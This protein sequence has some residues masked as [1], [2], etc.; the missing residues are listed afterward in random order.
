MVAKEEK[1]RN[2]ADREKIY[3]V[4]ERRIVKKRKIVQKS[5]LRQQE[6]KKST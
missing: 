1:R 6:G 2:K 5:Q 4:E 3:V